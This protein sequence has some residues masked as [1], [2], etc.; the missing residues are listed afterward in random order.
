MGVPMGKGV[1]LVVA[2]GSGIIGMGVPVAVFT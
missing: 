1:A 2:T